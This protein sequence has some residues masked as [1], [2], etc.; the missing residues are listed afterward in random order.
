ML[1]TI[2][3]FIILIGILI[4]IHELGHFAAAKRIGVRVETFSLGFGQ[5]LV[6]VIRGETEYR[7]S[8]IPFGGY[9]KMSGLEMDEVESS[10][11]SRLPPLP[12]GDPRLFNSRSRFE[13][14]QIILAGPVMNL[15]LAVVALPLV[16]WAGGYQRDI[17]SSMPVRVGS[18]AAGSP[19]AQQGIQVGDLITALNGNPIATWQGFW[20]EEA[21]SASRPLTLSL[22][23][24]QE[25]IELEM[26]LALDPGTGIGT[27]GVKPFETIIGTVVPGSGAEQAGLRRGDIILQVDGQDCMGWGKMT[28]LI[29]A[30]AMDH[31]ARPLS[32]LFFRD[33]ATN[34]VE[35]VPHD[36]RIGIS[37]FVLEQ[38]VSLGRAWHLGLEQNF[39]WTRLFLVTMG[40]L[41]TGQVSLR[42]MAGPLGIATVTGEAARQ[43]FGKFLNL[44]AFISLQLGLINLFPIPVL[45]GGHLMFIGVEAIW[46]RPLSPRLLH[47]AQLVGL[48]LLLS[49]MVVISYFDVVRMI[50]RRQAKEVSTTESIIEDVPAMTAPD[51]SDPS[52]DP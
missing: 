11:E 36:Q 46:R 40:K 5:K 24:E 14:L 2:G 51:R 41:L 35:V 12:A 8:L 37:Y 50:G 1:L 10:G 29:Q 52:T 13:R 33:G 20:Q 7:V 39:E 9:V 18:V 6:G 4:F 32:I 30:G 47:A 44:L 27:M 26:R 31:P 43:G 42:A 38:N 16:F 17:A 45:D 34:Q 23:R 48:A 3:S 15:L 21:L 49:L 25:T 22:L 28:E 19:A